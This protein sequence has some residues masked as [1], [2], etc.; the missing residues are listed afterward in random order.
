[1]D[2]PLAR[3]AAGL[4][5]KAGA[6]P[7]AVPGW[8]EEGRRRRA[9]ARMPPFSGGL[10]GGA[11]PRRSRARYTVTGGCA[12]VHLWTNPQDEI[13][14][15]QGNRW[16]GMK[17]PGPGSGGWTGT[18]ADGMSTSASW[19][20]W[21]L[22]CPRRRRRNW[23]RGA[24]GR[25]RGRTLLPRRRIEGPAAVAEPAWLL[26]GPGAARPGVAEVLTWH[27]IRPGSVAAGG[28]TACR[29]TR[30]T[31]RAIRCAR[32]CRGM[33][34]GAHGEPSA[35]TSS[36]ASPGSKAPRSSTRTSSPRPGGAGITSG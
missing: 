19:P 6:D 24:P 35:A 15:V 18:S 22:R 11:A 5:R 8:I 20:T 2:E 32:P 33:A 21:H 1:M 7:E 31:A 34:A 25:S 23:S 9:A 28:R 29:I 3:Q 17:L 12:S 13:Y 36:A 16:P 30:A 27:G 4:C 26:A 10:H 14:P